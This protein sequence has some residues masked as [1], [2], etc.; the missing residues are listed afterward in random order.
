MPTRAPAGFAIGAIS[1]EDAIAAFQARGLLR[2]S[3][4]WQEVWQAEHARAFAVAGVMRLD[5]LA[6]IRAAVDD[7]VARGTDLR[8]FKAALQ[9]KLLARGW[10][11]RMEITDPRSGEIRTTTFNAQR[12]E[13]IYDVNLRQSHAAGRWARIQRSRVFTHIVYRTMRDEKVRAS[14][15]P[16]DNVVLPKDHPWW[17]THYPPNGW[18]CRCTAYGID[19]AGIKQLQASAP[20]DAPV[21]TEAP[22][23]TNVEFTNRV[24]GQVEQVP[25]GID[26]GFAYNPGR[27]H[28]QRGIEMLERGLDAVQPPDVAAR[29]GALSQAALLRAV[30]ARM[31]TE[32]G[33]G[34]FLRRPPPALKG[35][36]DYGLPVAV[37]PALRGEPRIA[38]VSARLLQEQAD[39]ADYPPS[40]PTQTADWAL[41]QAVLDRGQ[42]LELAPGRVVWWWARGSGADR[43]VLV[44]E[45]NRST[46]VWWVQLV[47][48]LTSAEALARYPRL[49]GLV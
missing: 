41:A 9:E 24:T 49:E 26:P 33:F 16:W 39:Q 4:R 35:Q 11:G 36:A 27:V 47:V 48:Q 17:D 44:V 23:T 22:P 29:S 5:V 14:H 2:P 13:L 43:R 10:W 38:S 28:V 18:R 37:V 19:A 34:E 3:F 46:L 7:A 12:L 42:R 40:V 1:P 32:R 45:A 31:R 21:R 25:R 15:R 20:R 6:D 8:D 30:V